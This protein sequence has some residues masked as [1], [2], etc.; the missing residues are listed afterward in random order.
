MI[1][2][3]NQFNFKTGL[4]LREY[5]KVKSQYA[6]EKV[7]RIRVTYSSFDKDTAPPHLSFSLRCKPAKE[8]MQRGDR[9]SWNVDN[10]L[11]PFQ[12][13]YTEQVVCDV[14]KWLNNIG[15]RV[16]IVK[17]AELVSGQAFCLHTDDFYDYRFHIPVATN[18]GAMFHVDKGLY[19]MHDVGAMYKMITNKEHACWNVGHTPRVHLIFDTEE[20]KP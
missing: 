14:N 4:L 19:F 1:E 18:K 20:L 7:K 3:I 10:I 6:G 13:S 8:A 16:T 12:G 11:K 15:L 5:E 9:S 17:Y 2:K